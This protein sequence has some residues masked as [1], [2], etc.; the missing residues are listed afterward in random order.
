MT[1]LRNKSVIFYGRILFQD[2]CKIISSY[3]GNGY[4]NKTSN[5][6]LGKIQKHGLGTTAYLGS[7][8]NIVKSYCQDIVI[9][10]NV[11]FHDF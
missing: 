10:Q 2:G 8:K 4:E 7:E 3:K 6:I 1:S 9:P 11:S 5:N